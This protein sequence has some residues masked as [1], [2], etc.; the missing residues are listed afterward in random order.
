MTDILEA[1]PVEW[2]AA[3]AAQ[4]VPSDRDNGA[5]HVLL[6]NPRTVREKGPPDI[7]IRH[8]FSCP[9]TS[10]DAAKAAHIHAVQHVH[11]LL[12]W[13]NDVNIVQQPGHDIYLLA[14]LWGIRLRR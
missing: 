13:N 4:H 2:R 7:M 5:A 10:V 1:A 12:C 3:T 11:E 9:A 8:P 14:P 6:C